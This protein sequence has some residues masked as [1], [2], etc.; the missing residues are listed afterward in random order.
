[1]PSAAVG[2]SQAGHQCVRVVGRLLFLDERL[3]LLGQ[4]RRELKVMDALAVL[5]GP[6]L[7]MGGSFRGW[8]RATMEV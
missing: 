7:A 5:G 8:G 4:L 6:A 2:H 3:D 1:M